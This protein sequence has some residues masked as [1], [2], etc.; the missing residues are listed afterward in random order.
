MLTATQ[1]NLS[2]DFSDPAAYQQAAR[3]LATTGCFVAHNLLKHA[4][5]E[6]VKKDI[7]ALIRIRCHER[8]VVFTDTADLMMV[9]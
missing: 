4:E 8:G 1:Q 3:L 2:V 6:A 9:F 7:Q 5:L